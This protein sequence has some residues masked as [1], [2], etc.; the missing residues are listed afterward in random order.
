M[1][2]GLRGVRRPAEQLDRP[3]VA[4]GIALLERQKPQIVRRR[5]HLC[6]R[7]LEQTPSRHR[8][9]GRAAAVERQHG[10]R[11]GRLPIPARRA[12]AIPFR[13]LRPILA[14]AEAVGIEL[15]Q[16][17]H[18]R[19]II[20]IRLDALGRLCEGRQVE[21]ALECAIGEIDGR[22]V[23]ARLRRSRGRTARHHGD[24]L[25]AVGVERFRSRKRGR[26]FCRLG[27]EQLLRRRRRHASDGVDQ[28]GGKRSSESSA[29]RSLGSGALGSSHSGS[30]AH[31]HDF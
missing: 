12:E 17:R 11:I 23:G 26:A 19:P 13:R 25:A 20:G 10:Q 24:W 29:T 3:L 7:G 22:P 21:P 31:R 8:V 16:Q 4:L 28:C 1:C 18:R 6:R 9:L 15:A 14:H 2:L 27:L 30:A 5:R